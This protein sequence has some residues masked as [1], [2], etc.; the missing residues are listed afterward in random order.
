MDPLESPAGSPTSFGAPSPPSAVDPAALDVGDVL[1]TCTVV[2]RENWLRHA[3]FIGLFLGFVLLVFGGAAAIV[4][5]VAAA[6]GPARTENPGPVLVG[7]GIAL[8][9][10][11][12]T[13]SLLGYAVMSAGIVHGTLEALRGRRASFGAM[14]RTTFAHL[15]S[16]IGAGFLAWLATVGGTILCLVPGVI[17][18]L[19]LC[20]IVPVVLEEGLGPIDAITRSAE[21]T[22]GHRVEIFLAFLAA[23]ALAFVVQMILSCVSMVVALPAPAIGGQGGAGTVVTM[24]LTGV[25]YTVTNLVSTVVQQL[26]LAYPAAVIYARRT[27]L[28]REV[29]AQALAE[30]FG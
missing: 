20:L 11:V 23:Y 10:L 5:A 4:L 18:A 24:V 1:R 3:G 9:L 29:D 26:A 19:T 6:L 21:L 22:R 14:V 7:G 25:L 17:A 16:L 8:F 12:F 27:G 15:P 28:G 2:F 13:A 30:V